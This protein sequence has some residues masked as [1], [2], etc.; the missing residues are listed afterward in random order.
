MTRKKRF[1]AHGL[2]TQD[3]EMSMTPMIDVTFLVLIFFMCTLRFKTLE[4]QLTAYLPKDVGPNHAPSDLLEPLD[5][6]IHVRAAGTQL[7]SDGRPWSPEL[8]GRWDF[9]PDR[10][11]EYSIGPRRGLALKDLRSELARL[12][13]VASGRAISLV[14]GEGTVQAEAVEVLDLL[15]AAGLDQVRIQGAARD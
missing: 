2:D 11:V 7:A 10:R 3:I 14:P 12:D 1:S 6:G 4:G 8:G 9:G 15:T 5:V 13:L